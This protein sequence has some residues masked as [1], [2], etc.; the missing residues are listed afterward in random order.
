MPI[1]EERHDRRHAVEGDQAW[2]ESYY[3]NGYD[4]TADVGLFTRIG[5]RPNDGTIDV[6]LS[7]W[8]P[9]GE[10][11]EL[12]HLD[13]FTDSGA[14]Q[15]RVGPVHYELLEPMASWRLTSDA[16]MV[17]RPCVRGASARR[18]VNVKMDLLFTADAPPIGT[19]GEQP[20]GPQSQQA[21]AAAGTTGKGHFEQAGHYRGSITVEGV[22]HE[23]TT[24]LGNR[25]R[26]W[27]PRR[28]GGPSMWRWFSI[29]FDGGPHF[30]G[31]R[32]GT[33]AGDL[34]RGWVYENGHATSVREWRLRT[35]VADDHVTQRVVHMEV[36]DKRGKVHELRGDVL[37]VADIGQNG[38]T[39]V[40][41]GLTKWTLLETGAVGYGV[42]E[43]LHQLDSDGRPVVPVA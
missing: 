28:W 25:D 35:E 15:L 16:T 36:E 23:V 2:S 9:G 42:A 43:Y 11:A 17:A 27:G 39:V 1:L 20:G 34:H 12:R 32:L 41:E 38:G 13:P 26:S 30:G 37:R 22:R 19:D 21:A 24:A 29:N 40:N 33:T 7:V 4:P 6:G 5:C 14:E 31:I 8:L 10:L 18:D 3:F